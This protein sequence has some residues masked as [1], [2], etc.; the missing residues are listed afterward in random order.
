ML[1]KL[2]GN[3]DWCLDVEGRLCMTEWCPVIVSGQILDQLLVLGLGELSA[4]L[5]KD[6]RA[7]ST[8]V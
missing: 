2:S 4:F 3:K 7:A 5:A 1:D 8:T 6:T